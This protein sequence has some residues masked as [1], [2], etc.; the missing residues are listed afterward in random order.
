[1]FAYGGGIVNSRRAEED[2]MFLRKGMRSFV[3]DTIK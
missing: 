3:K 1:M 2:N